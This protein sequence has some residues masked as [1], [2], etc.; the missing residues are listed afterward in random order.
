[1][2]KLKY[3]VLEQLINEGRLEDMIKKYENILRADLVRELSASDPSG[4]NKYLD[5]MCLQREDYTS[6]YIIK[7][8]ECFHENLNR[9]SE[10]NVNTIYSDVTA[11][12]TKIKKAPKDIISY[13]TPD[14]IEVMCKY[15]EENVPKTASRVK[16]YEDDRWL[17]VS[18]LTHKASCEYGA[19]SSWCVS[20]SNVE[21]YNRYTRDGILVFFIDKTGTS[22]EKK[23]AN[24]YK[25][26]VNIKT[27]SQDLEDW[28]WYSM[29]DARIDS[30]LMMN[31]V[32]KNLLEIT[33]KYST[34]VLENLRKG[35]EID[36][37]VLTEKSAFWTKNNNY[38]YIFLKEDNSYDFLKKYDSNQRL[39]S[40]PR[41]IKDGLPVVRI[42]YGETIP[43][44]Y[45]LSMNWNIAQSLVRWDNETNNVTR[46]IVIERLNSRWSNVRELA[47]VI[48]T[49]N[50]TDKN[51]IYNMYIDRFNKAKVTTTKSINV[52]RLQIGDVIMYSPVRR[53]AEVPVKV[54]SVA[55][56]SIG[57]ENGKRVAKTGSNYKDKVTGIIQ[58]VDD[59][60]V[61]VTNESIWIRKRII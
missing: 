51:I 13:P 42:T 59:P 46:S 52:E 60:V 30:H 8:V 9:L 34:E 18:P 17:V 44:L 31:L 5:W 6:E 48:G 24:V 37:S 39:L 25:F 57:L 56:K 27:Q 22:L 40:M 15:F 1:M 47:D 36:E 61:P 12:N 35:W 49:L 50:E 21:Y 16:I 4:N 38:Y 7:M 29:S 14:D 28:E 45:V 55:N 2:E 33:S 19:F 58:I 26:A 41:I 43:E 32:P 10:K 3:I 23:D 53:S 20:T 54:V 11:T